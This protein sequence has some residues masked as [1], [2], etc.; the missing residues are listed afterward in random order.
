MSAVCV[1]GSML[2]DHVVRVPRWPAAGETL[3]ATAYER[4]LGGKGFNQ[5][6][7]A[8]R[9]GALVTMVGAV[10]RDDAGTEFVT[11]L[12]NELVDTRFV[13]RAAQLPTGFAVP[14]VEDDSAD[15]AIVIVPLA[16]DVVDAL[17]IRD[18]RPAIEDADVLGL[19]LELGVDIA[20]G[21]AAIARASG[22][23]VVLNAAPAVAG[24]DRLRGL[25]D[26]LVVNEPELRAIAGAGDIV[27]LAQQTR[28][29]WSAAS[30]IVTLGSSGVVAVGPDGVVSLAGH[31]VECVDSVGAG[32]A[33]CGTLLAR[34]GAGD[35][36]PAATRLANAAG[37]LAVTTAGA[38]P[39]MPWLDEVEELLAVGAER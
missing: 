3:R 33:F 28:E 12:E 8:A 38:G 17:L 36:V 6:V 5:A 30:V 27:D 37:A 25:V 39:A 10:G 19:Q 2:V 23:T 32:D 34:L 29:S 9:A 13:D 35:D 31:S 18:A 16:N 4:A 11:F 24:L 26:H 14:V 20:A 15:N 21:A 22:T 7:A 1:I